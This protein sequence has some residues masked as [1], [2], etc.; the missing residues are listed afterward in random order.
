MYGIFTYIWRKFMVNVGKYSI[1]G[2]FGILFI[3]AFD[4]R[5]GDHSSFCRAIVSGQR[6]FSALL[7]WSILP[8]ASFQ[9]HHNLL[10]KPPTIDTP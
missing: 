10:E 3:H 7:F 4:Q 2:A 5:C 9:F 6:S 8:P 1:R